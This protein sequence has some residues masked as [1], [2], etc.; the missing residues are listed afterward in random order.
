MQAEALTSAEVEGLILSL[1]E[2][3][4]GPNSQRQLSLCISTLNMCHGKLMI[5]I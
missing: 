5:G 4:V 3:Q 1:H 2:V